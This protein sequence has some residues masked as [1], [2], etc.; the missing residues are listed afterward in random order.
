ML[1]P[2][3]A[4][5]QSTQNVSPDD[6]VY[7]FIDRL[8]AARL[9]DTVAVGQRPMSRRAVGHMLGEARARLGADTGW[10]G[11]RL[12]EYASLYP[13][14]QQ[15]APMLQ[16]MS[17]EGTSAESPSRGIE[18]DGNGAIRVALNPLLGNQL[19]RVY[20]D[21][22][23]GSYSISQSLGV[24][25]WLALELMPRLVL[26]DARGGDVR[27]DGRI[28]QLYARALFRNA[29]VLVGRDYLYLG[30]GNSAGLISSLNPRGI[31]QVRLSS[32][33]PFVLPWLLRHAGPIQA[34]ATLGDA[35]RNQYFPHTRFFAY[36]VTARPH[37]R[38]EIGT[39]LSEHVGGE[40]APGGTFGQKA[41]DAFP[42]L[43]ALFLH[44]NFLFSNKLVSVDLRYTIPGLRGVQFY[45]EGA[46]DDFDMRRVRSVFTE[47]AGYVWGLSASC[48]RECGPLR[49]STEYHV[50]GLRYY[51]HGGFRDGYTVDGQI[52]GD[53]LGPRGKAG[54]GTVEWDRGLF[55]V[56]M[57]AAYE[58]RSGHLYGSVTTTPD[59]SDFRFVVIGTKPTERRWRTMLT[60]NRGVPSS[61][62][63]YRFGLGAERVENFAHVDGPW[64]T[65]W[66]AQAGAQYRPVRR[67]FR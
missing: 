56:D 42:L 26:L 55:G 39:G 41:G 32:D 44:R 22:Q 19:G 59:D 13:V 8:V 6:P 64:R 11:S 17:V 67:F 66:M 20:V 5:A 57:T 4:I 38:F 35:G 14:E 21:G 28:E 49:V 29:A 23:T 9:V 15:R 46:F 51:T 58:S 37:R 2:A 10:I 48:F 65:N 31:D 25:R 24:T 50:T 16:A 33:R 40:G 1:L 7:G 63:S 45:A 52:I 47:D 60:V 36:K 18:P 3:G 43:D 61:V 34:M 12:A 27:A 54:Y 30:Q 53:Q 62:L